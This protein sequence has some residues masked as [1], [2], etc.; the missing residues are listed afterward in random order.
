MMRS[1]VLLLAPAAMLVAQTIDRT[2][3]P[4][5]PPVPAYKLPPVHQEKLG[6][7]ME[8]VMVEDR[9]F[10]L[11]TLRLTFRNI[12]PREGIAETAASLLKEG[13]GSRTSQQIAEEL[14]DIGGALDAAAGKD[15]LT[16]SGNVLAENTGK[17]LELAADYVRRAT[18]PE[19]EVTLRKQNRVQELAAERAQSSTLADEKLMGLIYGGHPYGRLLPSIKEIEA[20]KREQLI[21]FRD[22]WL[23]P[24]NAV[25]VIVGALP[26]R[27]Q[28]MAMLN[29]RFGDWKTKPVPSVPA[30]AIPA[31]QRSIT[32]VDRPG[33]A[34]AD[35]HAG[36]LAVTRQSPDFFP[37]MVA[38]TVLGGGASSRMFQNIREKEGFAYDAHSEF[39]ARRS[40]GFFDA[41]TQVRDEV[42]QP[43]LKAMMAEMETLAKEPVPGAELSNI[44]SYLSGIFVLQI[45]S[46]DGLANE[47]N[48]VKT[49]GLP[50]DYLE[51]YVTRMRSVEPD[52][53][54]AVARKYMSPERSAIVV[55]GDAAKV[56]KQLESFGKVTKT[57]A[58]E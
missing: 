31:T 39:V 46:Q 24:N 5:T 33:S 22:T 49:Q 40:G 42:V 36:Q 28:L 2:K 43:A 34:Q 8:V 58:D 35:I 50:N 55:V 26:A 18:F 51:T 48:M 45:A 14:A 3:I 4:D 38:N 47:L 41:V 11:V 19:E 13:A 17:L 6:N 20:I 7:G 10:P 52:Q 1:L 16:V 30:P 37:L 29:Q 25:L 54:Q 57:K 32:L 56:G 15:T 9:R 12:D 44:K 27:S 21:A 23:V 53:I